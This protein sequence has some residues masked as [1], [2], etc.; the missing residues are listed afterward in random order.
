MYQAPGDGEDTMF[1]QMGQM[2]Q[3]HFFTDDFKADHPS[4]IL[5]ALYQRGDDEDVMNL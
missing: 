3:D 1:L 5:N 4:K 2:E